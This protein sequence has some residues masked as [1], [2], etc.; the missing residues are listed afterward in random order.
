MRKADPGEE[1]KAV[2]P[3]DLADFRP[4]RFLFPR[5]LDRFVRVKATSR[6]DPLASTRPRNQRACLSNR[7]VLGNTK[8]RPQRA[9]HISRARTRPTAEAVYNRH[10]YV[11]SSRRIHG[12]PDLWSHLKTQKLGAS[13]RKNK[14]YVRDAE[15]AESSG[16][17]H[18]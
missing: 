5:F 14:E 12:R 13:P 1:R 9:L 8:P 11:Q 15:L 17:R 4:A 7:E 16:T 18:A 3:A 10:M 6:S 2:T